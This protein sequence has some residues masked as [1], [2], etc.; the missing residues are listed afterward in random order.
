MDRSPL[1]TLG[2]GLL[3]ALFGCES[4]VGSPPLDTEL[5][6]ERHSLRAKGEPLELVGVAVDPMTGARFVLDRSNAL[7]DLDGAGGVTLR[8]DLGEVWG[9]E[10]LMDLCAV[11]DSELY[12]V[13]PENGLKL[14][15]DTETATS[16]FCIVPG[17][18]DWEDPEE[19]PWVELRHETHAIAC[20]L[21]S[22]T[23][24]AQPQ[25]V[26]RDP[27]NPTPERSEISTYDLPSGADQTWTALPSDLFLAGGM[28]VLSQDVLVL[29]RDS[30]LLTFDRVTAELEPLMNLR[31]L[32]VER[33]EGLAVDPELQTL[34]V[35][36]GHDGELV[37]LDLN[38]VRAA[39]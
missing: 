22:A 4:S 21:A 32:G 24:Y 12:T 33:I 6:V 38:L 19:N 15:L 5:V 23:I 1:I 37:T 2:L 31:S 18:E 8:M 25:T 10:P 35:A 26:P 36:D 39:L 20:D 29:G 27:S 34:L 28:A 17:M 16:H 9:N 14:N 7:Y 30:D 3:T 13:A 11:S